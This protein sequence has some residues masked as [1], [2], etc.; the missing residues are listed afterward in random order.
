MSKFDKCNVFLLLNPS[1]NE[2]PY[3]DCWNVKADSL[4]SDGITIF[5]SDFISFRLLGDLIKAV[6]DKINIP[7]CK[8]KRSHWCKTLILINSCEI[9]SA[10]IYFW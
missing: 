4:W 8:E 1:V 6:G 5:H 9:Y 3:N 2:K 7:L 10:Y